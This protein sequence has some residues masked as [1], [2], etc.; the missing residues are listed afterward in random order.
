METSTLIA[1]ISAITGPL[2]TVIGVL[3]RQGRK[4]EAD[5]IADRDKQLEEQAQVLV[6]NRDHMLAALSSL[7]ESQKRL[8]DAFEKLVS[9]GGR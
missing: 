3:Y 1:L 5:R 4:L 2:L 9:G 6:I 7:Q 8:A